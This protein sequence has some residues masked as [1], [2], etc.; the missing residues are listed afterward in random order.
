MNMIN[1]TTALK[2]GLYILLLVFVL[3]VYGF[4]DIIGGMAALATLAATI[5][6]LKA[7]D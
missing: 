5:V 4:F 3:L 1:P 6:I 2:K 7:V